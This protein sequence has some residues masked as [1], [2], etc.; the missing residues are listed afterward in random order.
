MFDEPID[1]D[2]LFAE[3]AYSDDRGVIKFRQVRDLGDVVNT[4][5]SFLK[6]NLREL[7]KGLLYI[8]GPLVLV[9]SMV[10]FVAQRQMEAV[11]LDP[12]V[13]D[14]QDPFELYTQF[15]SPVFLLSIFVAFLIQFLFAAVLYAYMDLYRNGEAGSITPGY[16]WA[17]TREK[18]WTVVGI[19]VLTFLVYLVGGLIVIVPCLGAIAWLVGVVYLTPLIWLLYPARLLD[20]PDLG[21]AVEKVR[22]LVRGGW[23]SNFG[24]LF[25]IGIVTVVVALVCYVPSA[26]VAFTSGF[27]GV[28]AENPGPA[29]TILLAVATVLGYLAYAMY[30]IPSVA[31][32]FQY[33]SLA[34][35]VDATS[36][37]RSVDRI[38]SQ[39]SEA[40]RSSSER[41]D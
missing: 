39:G 8:V 10:S 30:A 3:D 33:F 26:I 11:M 13:F 2:E 6:A 35:Q 4:T 18:V 9:G 7:G 12:M 28:T 16:L 23:W 19:S 38:A 27:V 29:S 21:S 17:E 40:D 32:V 5:F 25:V 36:L 1:R 24:V 14:A 34:E 20:Q 22:E 41:L 31:S 37:I 15:F